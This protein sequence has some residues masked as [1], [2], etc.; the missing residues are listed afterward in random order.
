[1]VKKIAWMAQMKLDVVS[2]SRK[3]CSFDFLLLLKQTLILDIIE[4]YLTACKIRAHVSAK[5]ATLYSALVNTYIRHI[6]E[7][8]PFLPLPLS[9]FTHTKLSIIEGVRQ[10]DCGLLALMIPTELQ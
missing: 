3:R 2:I 10:G 9:L 1:M 8:V 6:S 7:R 4:G 5:L